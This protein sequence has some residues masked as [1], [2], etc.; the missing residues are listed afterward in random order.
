MNISELSIRRPVLATVMTVIILLF[1]MI[2]YFYI[3]VRE[4]PSVDNPII[5]VSCSYAGANAD[6]IENQITEPL[7]QNINGIPGI[8]S[9]TSVS[10]QGQSRITVEFELSVDLE[11]AAND[12]RDKVSRAQRYLPRDCDPPT[13]SKADADASPILMVALQSEKRSLLELSEIADLTVKEQLQ[14]I[15]DVS[16]VSIWGE[17]KYSMRLWLDPIKMA[18]YGITPMDVK[19]AV[20]NENVELPS[21]SIEG[22]TIEL[23]IRT[24][25]LMNTAKMFDDLIVKHEG[26]QIIRFSDIGRAELGAADIKSYMK[27]NGVP[28]VGVVVVPQPGANHIN[29]A[30]AVYESMEQMKKDLPDDVHYSYGFD[31]T[32]FIRAS[33]NEV[34]QTVY[35]AFVLVIIIIFLFL[36]DWRVTLVPCIVIPVSLVGSFFIMYLFGFSI[37]VLTMLAVVLAVGLV[38]DDAIVMTENI[39]IRIE[40]G[41]NPKKA[42][43]EGAKEIFFAVI[44]TT[45]TL[46]AVFFP[47]VFM[48]GTTGRLF[49]EFSMVISGA[50]VISSFAAL[51]FTPMLATKLLK[52]QKKKNAFYRITEPFF[53]GMNNMYSRSLQVVLRHRIWTLP[54]IV[55]MLGAIVYLWGAIPSEMAPLEDRS[56]I[57][58]NTRGAEG[59]T[60]EYI[61]DYTEDINSI[62]DSVIP[63]A[64]AVTARVSSGSGNIQIRLKDMGDRD[65]TQ[66]EAAEKLSQAVKKKTKARAFVQQ[67]S[68]FGGRR[69][70]MPIQYVLQATNIE[71]LEKVLPVF[72]EK[73]YENPVF[74]MADVD[75]KF[76]KPEIRIHIN[77]DKANIMGVNTRDLS[78]TLQYGLSG[79]RMGYFYMNGK[80]YEILGEINRQQRNKP[81]D[82]RAIYLRSSDG[83]MIQ[84]D[85]L[86]ELESSI[87]PPKLYRYNRFV[88]ATISAGLAEGKTIGQGLDEMDKIAKEVLDDTFRT[89]LSGDSKEFRESSS[90]LMFA[91]ILA[92]VL[93]Y[94]ILAAQ[95]ESFKD[96]FI[97][98]LT[99]PLAIAGA[100]IFMYFN[101]ITMNV[102]S[103]IGIIMLIGLV[104]KNGIL[105]VEFANL[106]QENGEDKVTAVHDAALQRLRPILMTSASTVLGLIPLAFATGEGCNQRIAMG[107]AVVGGMVV[108]T[109]LTMYIVPAVYSYISTNRINKK[110]KNE[111]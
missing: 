32:K 42:G 45:V 90:S 1:G 105:I 107:I 35:E 97:I 100:L 51:T 20:D 59:V 92:L 95:F 5:S 17:K 68:S 44:S 101:D 16:S 40:Q 27:M 56:M 9:L 88:S 37:N 76:S 72:M 22:N 98:M 85:N 77:R 18:G 84:M 54:V 109:F 19:N 57:T 60:Y 6:V 3:G 103:Q 48:E 86:I 49:R 25:G 33:I 63:D 46:V 4:Y 39:Y 99:V 21:G 12:V 89:S 53:I 38:V 71:K 73:V 70:S 93:I 87:A 106:K 69:S 13:V 41:M 11:T 43:I 74:Q 31:N 82:L 47:I 79:Q 62:V 78:E 8:R 104:A 24:M 75:L 58:I 34:K 80:Q 50:V 111:K 81:A 64:D 10:Q 28:M 61:R 110:E 2:G 66:M 67:Q 65:Y 55:L 102:F 108:S 52:Q 30:D 26:N 94:L 96:P 14:T 91:F 15:S 23:N 29:I 7:E 83:K 36:R